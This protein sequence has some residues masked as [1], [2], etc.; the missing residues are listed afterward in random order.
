MAAKADNGM[1]KSK[2]LTSFFLYPLG[3]GCAGMLSKQF[4]NVRLYILHLVVD[5]NGLPWASR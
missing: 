3:K 5:V 4:E 1:S 2:T